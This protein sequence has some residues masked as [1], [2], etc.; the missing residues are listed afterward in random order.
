MGRGSATTALVVFV[1]A[2]LVTA[3]VMFV[4]DPMPTRPTRGTIVGKAYFPAETRSTPIKVG[5]V[6]V[7]TPVKHPAEWYL[8]IRNNGSSIRHVRVS[9]G[10]HYRARVGDFYDGETY[11]LDIG[12]K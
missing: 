9:R 10:T 11:P 8:Q 7:M 1:L 12:D 3:I 4:N 2:A 6:T 5:D